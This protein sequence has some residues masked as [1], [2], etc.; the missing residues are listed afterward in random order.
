MFFIYLIVT[1]CDKISAMNEL[2]Y[3]ILFCR[4]DTF[5]DR[6]KLLRPAMLA[7]NFTLIIYFF[8]N[9]E[10]SF[11]SNYIFAILFI[12]I[13][14]SF[15]ASYFFSTKIKHNATLFIPS[16]I[17]FILSI[18]LLVNIGGLTWL[19]LQLLSLIIINFIGSTRCN[20]INLILLS[21]TSVFAQ[22]LGG[23]EQNIILMQ[24]PIFMLFPLVLY[25]S[26]YKTK[27]TIDH[28]SDISQIHE[29][30]LQILEKEALSEIAYNTSIVAHEINN[31]LAVLNANIHL[32][33]R[34][35]PQEESSFNK[36]SKSSDRIKNIVQL[37]KNK[38]Y[39]STEQKYFNLSSLYKDDL[40]LMKFTLNKFNI[41]LITDEV[42]NDIY[43][44]G[45]L[46]ECSQILSNLIS[47][48]KDAHL[49]K[50]NKKKYIKIKLS[51]DDKHATLIV[52]DNA[53]GIP[54]SI[55][56]NIFD[57]S[58]TTKKRGEGTGLGLYYVK[59][60]VENMNGEISVSVND[61][62]TIFS[63]SF[64]VKQKEKASE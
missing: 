19:Y 58:F 40:S 60:V 15:V 23:V 32:L 24:L 50:D 53:G 62:K 20:V 7:V 21:S 35:L 13:N 28:I 1:K 56:D 54:K 10:Q 6:V 34:K 8:V 55:I 11:V 36:L 52:E 63:V 31:A 57:K 22:A 5:A 49:S 30:E 48:A 43:I 42:D 61:Q 3:D 37:I 33:Q 9:L 2:I 26:F 59:Q 45:N 29:K 47:N 18:Y 64:S 41:N 12:S 51:S 16:V 39:I 4:K 27:L 25:N 17:L 14:L 44:Y 38:S 46:T